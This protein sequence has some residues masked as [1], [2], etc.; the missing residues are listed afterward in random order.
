MEL[1]IKEL[2]IKS[3][4]YSSKWKK[5]FDVYDENLNIY[6]GKN[7]TF[8]E[9]GIFN[10]GS[11]KVWKEFF[12]PGSRIIGIDINKECKKFEE[13]G[14][15]VHIGNQSDPKFWNTFFEKVGNVDV[16]LDDGGHTN[17]DQIMTTVKCV[18]K[19]NDGGMLIVEDTHTSYMRL[20]NSK[21][22]FSFI[23]FA[24][25]I[26]D[27]VNYTANESV[28][29][30]KGNKSNFNF[31]LNNYIYSTHFYES[32]VIFKINR[33]KTHQ[34]TMFNNSGLNHNIQDLTWVGNELNISGVKNFIN[35][36]RFFR[37]R[38]LKRFFVKKAN[39]KILKKFFL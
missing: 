38:R 29:G 33:K 31:S 1:N 30:K 34:N 3:K 16:I 5:Y 26:I 6:K 37:L 18:N 10:G 21:N 17:L 23:N 12:G 9:I 24:K 11:L 14:I 8:V 28:F 22:S 2:F 19:I 7:I 20:Y 39:N 27:D 15:E 25:K 32:I 35:N 13:E 36:L 4:N